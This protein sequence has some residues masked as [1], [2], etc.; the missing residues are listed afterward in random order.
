MDEFVSQPLYE[1]SKEVIDQ[2]LGTEK[3]VNGSLRLQRI[4]DRPHPSVYDPSVA[5]IRKIAG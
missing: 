5:D 1:L 4:K 2:V 3:S